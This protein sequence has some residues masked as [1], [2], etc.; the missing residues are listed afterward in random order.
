MLKKTAAILGM[1]KVTI[2]TNIEIAERGNIFK[3]KPGTIIRAEDVAD[4]PPDKVVIIATGSQGE[5]SAALMRIATKK[6]K[7]ITFTE[8]DTVILSSSI[9]PGNE[10]R[11]QKLK[12]NLLRHGVHLL[13]YRSSD[14][15]ST[16]HGNT[17]EL[18]WMLKEVKPTFFMPAYGY[19]SMLRYHA[20]AQIKAAFDAFQPPKAQPPKPPPPQNQTNLLI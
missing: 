20:A 3:P 15:H 13:H 18:V 11:V 1:E 10:I 8:R 6:H 19:H 16:G 2:K 7:T 4:H 9:I 17:G 14:V 12:D 5:E